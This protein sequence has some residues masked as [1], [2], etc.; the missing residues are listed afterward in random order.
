MYHVLENIV[1][2]NKKFYCETIERP[3]EIKLVRN[4]SIIIEPL[5][6]PLAIEEEYECCIL[7]KRGVKSGYF[8]ILME[9]LFSIH[10]CQKGFNLK[11]EFVF[12]IQN[13][14]LE[15]N[16]KLNQKNYNWEEWLNNFINCP[17]KKE[18][19]KTIKFKKVI[20]GWKTINGISI[21]INKTNKQ[22]IFRSFSNSILLKHG[23]EQKNNTNKILFDIRDKRFPRN[24][25][26][27]TELKNEL[28]EFNIE[29]VDFASMNIKDQIQ[30]VS[31]AS[32]FISQHGAGLCNLVFMKEGSVV[33]EIGP[34]DHE[35]QVYN[36][37][38]KLFNIKYIKHEELECNCKYNG[39]SDIEKIRIRDQDITVDVRK[40]K[41]KINDQLQA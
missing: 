12:N 19:D 16:H 25:T 15:F 14:E 6:S 9:E 2:K 33:I 22:F 23:I 17:I 20:L 35:Y 3:L 36:Q 7:H 38:A 13:L 31:D 11:P 30:K 29:F 37:I 40:L 27:I 18:S 1:Y 34:K 39:N 21:D 8:H 24:L 5:L 4:A 10:Y 26:N 28:K 32:I 41:E